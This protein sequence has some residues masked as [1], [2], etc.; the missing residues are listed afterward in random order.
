MGRPSLSFLKKMQHELH[1][2]LLRCEF[3]SQHNK[4]LLFCSACGRARTKRIIAQPHDHRL[5]RKLHFRCRSCYS[6]RLVAPFCIYCNRGMKAVI[7]HKDDQGLTNSRKPRWGNAKKKAAKAS[8]TPYEP[9]PSRRAIIYS[10]DGGC[11][12]CS[13]KA[14]L[15][16]H[17]VKHRSQ[18]GSNDLDNLQTL[19]RDCHDYIHSIL[20]L[21]SGVP[22]S[23]EV[24]APESESKGTLRW[25]INRLA[26]Q[27]E[28]IAP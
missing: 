21:P 24:D 15:S 5:D 19:C 20:C 11:L 18:G 16:L 3:C 26:D 28:G 2:D 9:T 22:Y 7:P 14:D 17:H 12:R 4:L 6:Q 23:R 25:A 10:R 13:S 8:A 27:L 1:I